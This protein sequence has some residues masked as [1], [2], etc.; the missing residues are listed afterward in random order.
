MT[1]IRW[2]AESDGQA[3]AHVGPRATRTACGRP[4]LSERHA[5]PTKTR[6][7]TCTAAVAALVAP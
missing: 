2:I 5:W 6:C 7:E 4:A 3:H 1:R